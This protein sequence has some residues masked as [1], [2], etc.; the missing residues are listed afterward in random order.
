MSLFF[1]SILCAQSIVGK[2]KTIDDNTGEPRSIVQIYKKS[3]KYFGKIVQL[4]PAPGETENPLCKK[5][6]KELRNKP[7]VGM[8][9]ITSLS[10]EKG[11]EEYTG[12]EV[13]DP[14]SGNIYDCK[15]WVTEEGSLKLRGYVYFMYRTQTWIPVK[16]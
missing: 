1:G 3:D 7:V 10:K 6:P 9:I 15:V 16:D 5:C 4:F 8:E 14:E 13:L 2:W 11:I 12:G